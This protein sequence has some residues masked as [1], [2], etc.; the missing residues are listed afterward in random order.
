MALQVKKHE[1]IYSINK[2]L[3]Q[4]QDILEWTEFS[5]NNLCTEKCSFEWIKSIY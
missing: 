5:I 3:H 4:I 2:I 1:I